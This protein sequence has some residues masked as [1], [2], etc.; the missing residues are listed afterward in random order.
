[1]SIAEPA[2][3]DENLKIAAKSSQGLQIVAPSLRHP[4]E[5]ARITAIYDCIGRFDRSAK[6]IVDG[7]AS[8]ATQN[9]LS[10]GSGGVV[11][12]CP[13]LLVTFCVIESVHLERYG[14][15]T[16][17]V[18]IRTFSSVV[19][20]HLFAYRERAISRPFRQLGSPDNPPEKSR[21]LAEL[22]LRDAH[23]HQQHDNRT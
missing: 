9:E 5:A 14:N 23:R 4:G 12:V 16:D 7:P 13:A 6:K 22:E 1:M 10:C 18:T 8:R 3:F 20:P 15:G 11:V 17:R 21:D 19:F 2:T